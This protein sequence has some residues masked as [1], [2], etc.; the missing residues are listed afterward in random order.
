MVVTT[1]YA[2][3]DRLYDDPDELA[4]WARDALRV[5]GA[6]ET[7]KKKSRTRQADR[8]QGSMKSSAKPQRR[9]SAK[10]GS[11]KA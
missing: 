5:A 11:G 2:M 9:K 3:P 4:A 8:A 10:A 7:T 1:W 6:S